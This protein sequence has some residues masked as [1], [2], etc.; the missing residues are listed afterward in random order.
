MPSS[1]RNFF[2][3]CIFYNNQRKRLVCWAVF[4][5]KFNVP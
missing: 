1:Y 4:N 2:C 3:T 5:E